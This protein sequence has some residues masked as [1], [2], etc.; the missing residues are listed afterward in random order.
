MI[1]V[2]KPKDKTPAT[3]RLAEEWTPQR[4]S[5]G[6]IIA[7]GPLWR[8]AERISAS[9]REGKNRRDGATVHTRVLALA[10]LVGEKLWDEAV[11]DKREL[12]GEEVGVVEGKAKSM[13][14]RGNM[15][16]L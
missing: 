5:E 4:G 10:D 15:A 12:D 3:I 16:R 11:F 2:T 1:L 7:D 6:G 9:R 8:F 14:K 13:R